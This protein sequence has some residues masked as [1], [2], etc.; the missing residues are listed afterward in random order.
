MALNTFEIVTMLTVAV[1]GTILLLYFIVLKKQGWLT[2]KKS[3]E[4]SYLCPNPQCKRIFE[5]PITLTDLSTNPPRGYLAC[6][7]CGLDL[8]TLS[9]AK[10]KKARI[11]D[12]IQPIKK[13][14]LSREDLARA[15]TSSLETPTDMKTSKTSEIAKGLKAPVDAAE[16]KSRVETFETKEETPSKPLVKFKSQEEKKSFP[17][18]RDCAHFFGYVRRLPKNTPIPDECLGCPW[19]VEC[20]THQAEEVKA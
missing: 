15:T 19:I 14:H 4:T 11:A 7:Y 12:E 8:E 1:I 10:T 17:T 6:P 16:L 5:K 9:T 3:S 13:P 2:E 20:L 18:S